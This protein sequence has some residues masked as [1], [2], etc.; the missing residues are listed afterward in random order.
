M[1]TGKRGKGERERGRMGR[2]REM[3]SEIGGLTRENCW[4]EGGVEEE[5]EERGMK[6]RKEE[7]K[8]KNEGKEGITRVR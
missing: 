4:G 5:K 8:R 2:G 3:W 6:E 7:R 1:R